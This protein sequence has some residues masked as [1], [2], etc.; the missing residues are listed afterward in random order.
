MTQP[1]FQKTKD[2]ALESSSE[3]EMLERLNNL[4]ARLKLSK[5][6][7]VDPKMRQTAH[8]LFGAVFAKGCE[9]LWR[10]PDLFNGRQD[11]FAFGKREHFW[12]FIE[13]RWNKG[14]TDVPMFG[15]N[16]G[17]W[18]VLYRPGINRVI[19]DDGD[20]VDLCPETLGQFF[21]SYALVEICAHFP[22]QW[23]HKRWLP[24]DMLDDESQWEL[25]WHRPSYISSQAL[26]YLHKVEQ[27]L[28]C[29]SGAY[30]QPVVIADKN[31]QTDEILRHL[32]TP[33]NLREL[34]SAV[35][36]MEVFW[37]DYPRPLNPRDENQANTTFDDD[38]CPL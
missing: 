2:G 36:S 29:A 21:V 13:T 37:Y 1:T 20:R 12:G 4:C 14:T 11:A 24:Q 8:D 33:P 3:L 15:E 26:Y 9:V 35:K 30:I 32:C 18:A 22:G 27:I 10:W 28:V 7:D 25:L 17:N 19:L 34:E 31:K 6:V 5:R 23:H 16:Q 38:E